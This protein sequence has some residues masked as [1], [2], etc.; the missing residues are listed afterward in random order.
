MVKNIKIKSKE[1]NI[2]VQDRLF[3]LGYTWGGDTKDY[4]E[5]IEVIWIAPKPKSGLSYSTEDYAKGQ[6]PDYISLDDLY[7]LSWK[8]PITFKLNSEYTATIGSTGVAVG[9][10]KFPKKVM[11]KFMAAY[12][13]FYND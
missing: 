2:A 3:A 8:Q 9:C 1:H 11:D 13:T 12:Q 7:D 10:Q 5:N 6:N 4:I